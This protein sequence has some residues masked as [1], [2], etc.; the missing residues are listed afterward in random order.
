MFVSC[1][2]VRRLEAV[3]AV[4]EECA[5]QPLNV[6]FALLFGAFLVQILRHPEEQFV[7]AVENLLLQ[8]N[9]GSDVAVQILRG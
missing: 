9:G 6:G 1:V 7:E 4:D 5:N 3:Q 8:P 2:K